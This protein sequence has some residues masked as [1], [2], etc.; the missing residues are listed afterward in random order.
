MKKLLRNV[1]EYITFAKMDQTS[2]TL[3]F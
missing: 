2:H 3:A 1:E